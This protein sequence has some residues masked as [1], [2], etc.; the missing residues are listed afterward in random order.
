VREFASQINKP[1]IEVNLEKH[2][3]LDKVSYEE[4]DDLIPG[5]LELTPEKNHLLTY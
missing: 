2:S 5:T 4:E 1:L 3:K